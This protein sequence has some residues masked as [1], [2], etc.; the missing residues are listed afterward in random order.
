M[1]TSSITL[2]ILLFL[3]SACDSGPSFAQLCEQNPEICGEFHE[4]SWCKRERI[5]VGKANID[6]KIK[7]G[8][9]QQFNQLIAY[10]NY[11]TCVSHA[12][13]IEHIKLKEK[14]TRRIEN[15]MKAR[16]RI[17]EIAE[18]TRDSEHPRLL[19]FHWTRYL[20][21]QALEKFLALEGTKVLETPES[22]YELATYYIKRDQD[23]TLQLLFHAL[24]LNKLES[25]VN[26][27]IFKSLSSIFADKKQPKQ[28]YIW[29][30]VLQLYMPEDTSLSQST[31]DNYVQLNNLDVNFLNKVAETTLDKIINAS[32]T[33]PKF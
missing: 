14:Q 15:M 11:N 27:E 25:E 30:R 31:L 17:E 24:E 7:P 21:E 26:P 18:L 13:K 23:K 1:Q 33:S 9:I 16:Q 32:F 8:D 28:S 29:L 4:D 2:I 3:V 19:Y 10:E 12:S 22:Q 6:Y 20:N 5:A